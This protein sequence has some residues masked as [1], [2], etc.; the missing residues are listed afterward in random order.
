WQ[1]LTATS[2]ADPAALQD[3]LDELIRRYSEPHR[4]YHNCAHVLALLDQLNTVPGFDDQEAVWMAAF[5]HD[6]LYFPE[7][8]DNETESA[9]L[10]ENRL[11]SLNWPSER[12]ARVSDMIVRTARHDGQNAD[13]DT[14]HFLDADLSILGSASYPDY[15]TA[16]RQEYSFVPLPLYRSERAKILRRFLERPF[17]YY[18]P[19]FRDRFEALA[20]ENVE[21]EIRELEGAT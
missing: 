9:R 12:I 6:V 14:L 7:R 18:T 3:T 10:A 17:I 21:G 13:P 20:R 2:S 16:I 1:E 15:A 11:A 5:F 8:T 4:A 19:H